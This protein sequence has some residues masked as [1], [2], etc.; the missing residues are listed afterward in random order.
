VTQLSLSIKSAAGGLG[1]EVPAYGVFPEGARRGVVVVHEIF[2]MQP[3]IENVVDRFGKAQ[4][5]A[6]APDFF[7]QPGWVTC[8]R[9][10]MHAAATGEG[11]PVAV[12]EAARNYLVERGGLAVEN[13][14]L[15][16][17]CIA[18]GFV[19]GIGKGWGA[20]STNYGAIPPKERLDGIGPVIGCYGGR[21]LVFG[22]MG[23]RL[24][25]SLE[26]KTDL[27]IHEYPTVGHAFL[28]D[29]HHPIA[30]A[31]SY[32]FYRIRYDPEVAEDAW[33]HIFSFFEK[34]L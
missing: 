19:L 13:I 24:K 26:G 14:G 10:M 25:K 3:E 12:A 33:G 23:K 16:G 28:T 9:Q 27:K 15:I 21:D 5:A 8:V 32:P 30:K 4:Y 22:G 20:V 6:I 29:G 11:P 2:G 7:H 17:F 18:G 34:N 31:L 1:S